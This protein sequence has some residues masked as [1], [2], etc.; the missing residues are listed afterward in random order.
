[1]NDFRNWSSSS[2]IMWVSLKRGSSCALVKKLIPG[3]SCVKTLPVIKL[4]VRS[5]WSHWLLQQAC[6]PTQVD[7]SSS[8]R[9]IDSSCCSVHS[10]LPGH[11]HTNMHTHLPFSPHSSPSFTLLSLTLVFLWPFRG[12]PAKVSGSAVNKHLATMVPESEK[13]CSTRFLCGGI[14]FFPVC[15]W[16][17]IETLSLLTGFFI[18]LLCWASN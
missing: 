10:N 1:M 13:W 9:P 3:I 8:L 6:G 14:Q 15:R 18:V 12:A 2:A 5:R 11:T 16:L 4:P 7:C 17:E